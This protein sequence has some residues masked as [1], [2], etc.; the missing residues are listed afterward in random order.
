MNKT[1]PFL[2]CGIWINARLTPLI[3]VI[4]IMLIALL[5]GLTHA[6]GNYV[7]T[8]TATAPETSPSALITRSLSDVKQATEYIDGLG[9]PLQTN[10]RQG[11][12]ETSSG[13]SQDLVVPVT[14]DPFGRSN[15]A[16][17]PY[18]AATADGSYRAD[19]LTA[20]PAYYNNG[21]NPIAGQG[22]TGAN[23]HSQINFESS[24]LGRPVLTMAPGNSWVG[25]GRGVQT[26][27]WTNTLTDDVKMWTVNNSG[28]AG[29]FASYTMAGSYASGTLY[30]TISTDEMAHQVVEFKD[31]EGEVILKKV[32]LTSTDP[33]TGSGYPGWLCTYYIYDGLN[34]LRA[35]IQPNGV[36]ALS[37]SAWAFTA[38]ILSE[39]CFR[40]EYDQRNRMT[41]KK[42]PGAGEVYMVYDARDRLVMT[43]D[44]NLRAAGKWMVTVYDN[45]LDRPVQTGLLVA[46]NFATQLSNA[47]TSIN[48]PST[49]SN[50]ELLTQTHYD[51]Y[52]GLPTG[53]TANLSAAGNWSS[54]FASTDNG[55]F[56]YP[57]MPAQ[58]STY[59]TKGAITW[60]QAKVIG[61]AS[62]FLSTVNIYDDKGRVIQTQSQN[63]T[64][65]LDVSTMQYTWNGQ[66]LATVLSQ[67]KSGTSAQTTVIVSKD[68]FDILCRP[69]KT[70]KKIS[71]TLVNGNALTGWVTVSTMQYDQLGQ[72]RVKQ[73]GNTRPGGVYSSTPLGS[74]TMDYNI[75]G[76]LLGI[77]RAFVRN[78]STASSSTNSGETFTTPP[79]YSAGNYFG[80]ELGYDKNPTVG[81]SSWTG[82]TQYNGNIT[83]TIWKSVHDGQ[84]RKYD[85]SY[86]AVNRLTAA[87]F[88][89]YT[90][91]SFNQTA[92]INY[93]T[94]NLSYDANGNIL[95]MNQYGLATATATTSVIV[96]QLT[97]T[98]IAGTNRLQ[99][100][101][102]AAN[103]NTPVPG[104]AGY[105]GDYHYASGAG[106]GAVYTYD[107]NGNL[108]SDNNKK[109]S[110]IT[111]NYLNLPQT[112]S[113]TGKGTITY[114]YD[115][116][117]NKL[118]KQTAEGSTTTTTLYGAGTV[119]INNVLQ[120]VLHE[121]GRI[122]INSTNNGYIFDYF[123][124]DQLGNTRMTITDDNAAAKPVVDATSYYPFGLTMARISSKA[125]LGLENKY[126]YNGKELQHEE[127]SDGSG[128]EWYDYGAR[129]YDAQ[130]GRWH[131]TDN[132]AE[133]Y[134][135]ITPYAYAA[136]QPTN[137]IDPDGNLIIFINGMHTGD[138]GKPDYW[139]RTVIQQTL[140]SSR[141]IGI[142]SFG[143]PSYVN[144][145]KTTVRQEN[146]DLSV[147]DRFDDHKTISNDLQY[148]DGALGGKKGFPL[149]M[150]EGFREGMG[151]A[152]GEAHVEEIINSLKHTGGVISETLKIVTHSMGA[153][154]GKGFVQAII[155][156]AK[157][158]PEKA[159]GLNIAV[160]D[161]AS[162]QQ[163]EMEAVQGA[164]TYQFDNSGDMVV[165][166]GLLGGS[167][168]HKQK[169]VEGRDKES[170]GSHSIFDFLDRVNQ[171][172]AGKYI[173][174]NGQFVRVGN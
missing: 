159:K 6:Q 165:G 5:P 52:T 96:D 76:W 61:S 126:K 3:K 23:A 105:L 47:Y 78:L 99:S 88:T 171:L 85:F 10:S 129:M 136:N 127:F 106:S 80:F 49:A 110:S 55:Q 72:L 70:Q 15:I 163:N 148:I 81:S 20:Q 9:R 42:V 22:E 38:T 134:Q 59:T 160:Y 131:R 162:F 109:I 143:I 155:E 103:S 130:M 75:R 40:Y 57:Q 107:N 58:N 66:A 62:T 13:T 168:F 137:A 27:Y 132:K 166:Y 56:P 95:S 7:R 117:G 164:T 37:A 98:L 152:Y 145:Y 54:Q 69:V 39:Q 94:N 71:N 74:L 151:H 93:T 18:V 156:W 128:L 53:L 91:T 146:F 142:N 82:T 122:R 63:I 167:M 150:I 89:Q 17:L 4:G 173:F 36:A 8:W 147:M 161:F 114:T 86:D 102:D 14:Y 68:S 48:Y 135:N 29:V 157:A 1:F 30:K 21:T 144:K 51:D 28:T 140:I 45:N 25:A 153:A 67:Q 108:T 35:V 24:P 83:G 174:Q 46:S 141:L 77:N 97:Y 26:G 118:Q 65:G 123:L 100:V 84:I 32:Q 154:Y 119:Y 43:Q 33:G 16:Y 31:K 158:N 170:G 60:S 104:T 124:K 79:S 90:G 139:R 64:T 169:G 73:L 41:M 113:V 101:T 34:N 87:N 11:S 149:N 121:E 92:G 172:E 112:V 115:A 138:G 50:F 111:Y 44:A 125:A 120:F 2:K 12:L 133:L 116:S 19:A